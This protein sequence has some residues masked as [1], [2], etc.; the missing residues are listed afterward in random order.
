MPRHEAFAWLFAPH[1]SPSPASCHC[2]RTGQYCVASSLANILQA[3]LLGTALVRGASGER[4]SS[5]AMLSQLHA[6][7]TIHDNSG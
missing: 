2:R 7:L 4:A 6:D 1:L 5:R 3:Y